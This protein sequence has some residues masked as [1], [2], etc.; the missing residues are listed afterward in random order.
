MFNRRSVL[1][2]ARRVDNVQWHPLWGVLVGASQAE[3]RGFEARR[4]LSG[5]AVIRT[6]GGTFEPPFETFC[7]VS[8]DIARDG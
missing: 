2:V 3:G 4:P 5:F 1:L 8:R 7:S 6:A